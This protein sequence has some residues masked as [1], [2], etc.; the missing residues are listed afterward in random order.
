MSFYHGGVYQRHKIITESMFRL[1]TEEEMKIIEALDEYGHSRHFRFMKE[2]FSIDLP[3]G[4]WIVNESSNT[5]H[6]VKEAGLTDIRLKAL[7]LT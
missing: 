7:I 1:P 2:E 3:V 6:F 4:L 5:A